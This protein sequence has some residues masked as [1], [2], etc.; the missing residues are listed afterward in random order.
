MSDYEKLQGQL[1]LIHL[2]LHNVGL[3]PVADYI[4]DALEC[5]LDAKEQGY[6]K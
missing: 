1:L 2:E 6:V 5:L 4:E 3:Q